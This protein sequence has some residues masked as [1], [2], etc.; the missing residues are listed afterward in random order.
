MET[1][2]AAATTSSASNNLL[3]QGNSDWIK[4]AKSTLLDMSTSDSQVLDFM[5]KEL[6]SGEADPLKQQAIAYLM[7]ARNN[8]VTLISNVISTIMRG[9]D[10][11]VRNINS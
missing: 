4:K 2:S 3:G 1:K 6:G 10:A 5:M 9:R 7:N 11:V 8:L